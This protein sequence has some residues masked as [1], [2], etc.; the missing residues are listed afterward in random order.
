LSSVIAILFLSLFLLFDLAVTFVQAKTA[1]LYTKQIRIAS[2]K[3]YGLIRCVFDL[4]THSYFLCLLL[5]NEACAIARQKKT[6]PTNLSDF[7]FMIY[8]LQFSAAD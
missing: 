5:L 7:G 3:H 1:R 6:E 8:R 4:P 2:S